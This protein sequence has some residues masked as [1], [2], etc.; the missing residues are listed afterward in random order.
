M[1]HKFFDQRLREY[2]V[3]MIQVL[4]NL[5]T[6]LEEEKCLLESRQAKRAVNV[7][8]QLESQRQQAITVIERDIKNALKSD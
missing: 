1:K 4:Q 5:A 8:L 2:N 7:L 3:A 6:L